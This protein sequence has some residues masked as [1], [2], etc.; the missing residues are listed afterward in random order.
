MTRTCANLIKNSETPDSRDKILLHEPRFGT[1]GMHVRQEGVP[2]AI[3]IIAG[4]AHPPWMSLH[5]YYR[6]VIESYLTIIFL[7]FTMYRPGARSRICE[8][9]ASRSTRIPAALYTSACPSFA[10]VAVRPEVSLDTFM[11]FVSAMP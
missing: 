10:S 2:A 8:A 5:R 4:Q 9:E 11:V 7:P 3:G 1:G 6:Y